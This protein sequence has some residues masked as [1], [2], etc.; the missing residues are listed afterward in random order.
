[1][2]SFLGRSPADPRA[3]RRLS[4]ECHACQPHVAREY[5]PEGLEVAE[6]AKNGTEGNFEPALDSR[7]PFYEG[8]LS[9]PDHHSIFIKIWPQ[10]PHRDPYGSLSS[11]K[12]SNWNQ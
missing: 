11:T 8:R 4:R 6:K 9:S 1:V 7:G 10:E 12:P 2:R 5:G 3:Q